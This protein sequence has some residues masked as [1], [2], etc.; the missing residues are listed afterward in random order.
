MGRGIL[1]YLKGNF[2]DGRESFVDSLKNR[3]REQKDYSEI[4]LWLSLVNLGRLDEA[5]ARLRSHFFGKSRKREPSFVG[6]IA[7][8]LLFEINFIE[9]NG[10]A[11]SGDPITTKGQLCEAA[12]Y[13]AQL[14]L[15]AEGKEDKVVHLRDT[16]LTTAIRN[17]YEY[18]AAAIQKVIL[19][20][21]LGI[22]F[23]TN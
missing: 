4:W 15:L 6:R 1:H 13:A 18:K 3:S 22:P 11:K 16:C 2:A 14:L 23:R 21:R 9:L 5:N 17:S 8:L 20:E 7:Q 12:F 10:Y 19:A